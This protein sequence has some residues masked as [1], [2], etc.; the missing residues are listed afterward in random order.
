VKAAWQ[1][2]VQAGDFDRF[3]RKPIR[4]GDVADTV[5]PGKPVR[6]KSAAAFAGTPSPGRGGS[7]LVALFRPDPCVHDGEAGNNGWLQELS[8]PLTKLTWENAALVA[9]RT[10][11]RLKLADEDVVVLTLGGRRVEAPVLVLPGQA[12]DCVT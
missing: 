10:A 11:E 6:V 7:S 8:K 5:F 3:W 9:P 1:T 12:E 2:Q 4:D